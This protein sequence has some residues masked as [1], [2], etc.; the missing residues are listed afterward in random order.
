MSEQRY[1]ASKSR[2]NRPGWSVTFRHPLRTDARAKAGLKMRRG[3]GTA[4]DGEA[5]QLIAEMNVLLSDPS[6]WNAAKR[7]EAERIFSSVIV[8]AF[9]DEIHAGREDPEALR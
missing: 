8:S 4:D 1:T 6:W 2:S 3:L 7:A 5:N 9:Y